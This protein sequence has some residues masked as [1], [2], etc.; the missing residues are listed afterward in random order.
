MIILADR[1]FDED[2]IGLGNTKVDVGKSWQDIANFLNDRYDL[3]NTKDFYR[4]RYSKL[5]SR[6]EK[7]LFD[8]NDISEM[9]LKLKKERV[10]ISDE[11]VQNN[12]YIRQIA[13]DE[14]IK[15]IAEGAIEGGSK[16]S[17]KSP[18]AGNRCLC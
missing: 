13:R 2:L 4:K 1:V 11:R 17:R 16:R 8:S 10:K 9:L 3:C 15:E 14:T 6:E 7:E 5:V 12:A 18:P